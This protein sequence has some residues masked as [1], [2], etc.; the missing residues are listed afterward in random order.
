[1]SVAD[2]PAQGII[3][4]AV[5]GEQG[6]DRREVARA[7]TDYEGNYSL[8]GLPAGRFNVVPIAPTMV[9]PANSSY[10]G[11][12]RFIILGDGE[13]VEKIDFSLTQAG[14]ITGRVTDA[15]GK[16]VIEERLQLVPV[17]N[18][19]YIG[20]GSYFNPYMYQTDDRGVFRLYGI[21]PGRYTLSVGVSP[22]ESAVTA[23]NLRRSYY[24]RTF[25]PGETDSKKAGVI[26]VTE[27][28]ESKDINIKLGRPSQS[29]AVSGRVVDAEGRAVPNLLIG[30]GGYDPQQKIV[31]AYSY[32]QHRTN[33]RGEFRLETVRPGRFAVFVWSESEN[34]SDPVAFEVTDADVTGLE[35]KLKRGATITGVIQIEGITGKSV[36][37]KLSKIAI[38][39]SVQTGNLG[40]PDNR[41]ATIEPDGSFRITGLPSGRVHLFMYDFQIQKDIRVLRLERDGVAQPNGIEVKPGEQ[42][43]NVRVVF[44]YGTGSILGQVRFENGAPP[45]GARIFVSVY[46]AG[47]DENSHPGTYAQPDARGRFVIEGLVAG[48]YQVIVRAQLPLTDWNGTLVT[49]RQNVTVSNGAVTETTVVLDLKERY[50]P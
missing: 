41:Q 36:A 35:L 16:P 28:G 17:E 14:V 8:T 21:P 20:S 19:I 13:T 10:G 39:A 49:G 1:V 30:Y 4:I 43:T 40:P 25:Y 2:K 15:S 5:P 42:V 9:G 34:Y 11:S 50:T 23:G 18:S 48:D 44:E 27:G 12:G 6:P 45:E 33:A 26:E 29:F 38:G 24:P 7:V 3:V 47:E 32:G 31:T 46:K 22:E 37:A